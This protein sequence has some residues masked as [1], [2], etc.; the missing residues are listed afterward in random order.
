MAEPNFRSIIASILTKTKVIISVRNMPEKEYMGFLGK[1]ISKYILPVADGCVFQTAEAAKY[2]KKRLRKKSTIIPNPVDKKFFEIER[3]SKFGQII[4]VGRLTEQKNQKLLIDAFKKV[5]NRY[6]NIRLLICGDG[7]KKIQLEKYIKKNDLEDCIRLCGNV[8]NIEEY[9]QKAFL[10]VLPS[11]YEGMPNALME[12]MAVGLPV[13]S[14]NCP[15]GGPRG[16]INNRVNGVLIPVRDE[17]LLCAA[18]INLLENPE[19]A[20]FLGKNARECLKEYMIEPI[21]LKWENYI[22]LIL[23]K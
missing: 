10:F 14:T 2:F 6:D 15:C 8:E 1:I 22:K 7:E 4:T 9:L 16:L 20:N 11:D 3:D 21:T 23:S 5:H 17:D 18:I 12:A 19:L 13:I